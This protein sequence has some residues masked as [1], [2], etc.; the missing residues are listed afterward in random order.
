MRLHRAR[1]LGALEVLP[2]L[3][4]ENSKALPCQETSL[5]LEPRGLASPCPGVCWDL[6]SLR[7]T[8][9]GGEVFSVPFGSHINP[10]SEGRRPC[11]CLELCGAVKLDAEAS[12]L[13]VA[14]LAVSSVYITAHLSWTRLACVYRWAWESI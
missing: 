2:S 13:G 3:R 12:E 1:S 6:S 8:E 7:V 14:G 9:A 4:M 10:C 11:V 5:Q